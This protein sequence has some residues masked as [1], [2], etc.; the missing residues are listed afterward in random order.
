MKY[1]VSL[2][3]SIF[4]A[5]VSYGQKVSID[6]GLIAS[7]TDFNIYM[8]NDIDRKA[9]L[10]FHSIERDSAELFVM[11]RGY[12]IWGLRIT[13]TKGK[14]QPRFYFWD[15]GGGYEITQNFDAC[16][17]IISSGFPKVGEVITGK[18]SGSV[19]ARTNGKQTLHTLKG[20]FIYKVNGV[21][22]KNEV[23]PPKVPVSKRYLKTGLYRQMTRDAGIEAGAPGY[24]L[25]NS[26]T[27]YYLYNT[28]AYGMA[29]FSAAELI[30]TKKPS[31]AIIKLTIDR[32]FSVVL[33]N[34]DEMALIADDILYFS[35]TP[36]YQNGALLLP[37]KVKSRA[38]AE[39]LR[40]KLA[41]AISQ[42][43]KSKR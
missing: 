25:Y 8:Q 35:G 40:S 26:D 37:V 27:E 17:L 20:R 30:P 6:P 14:V 33:S 36:A 12:C 32:D 19:V 4:C 21:D 11:V 18:F 1:I 7:K 2:L 3:F 39:T 31:S 22:G 29:A 38:E 13:F 15:D 23:A 34:P 28:P 42:S 43:R 16:E 9:N 41:A 5:Q 10:I 24:M